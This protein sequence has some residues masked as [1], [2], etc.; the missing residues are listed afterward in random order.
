MRPLS[1]S[2]SSDGLPWFFAPFQLEK[3]AITVNAPALIAAG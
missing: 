1:T 2:V 3:L